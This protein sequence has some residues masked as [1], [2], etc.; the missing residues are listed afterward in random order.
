M[1]NTW[2][3]VSTVDE[4]IDTLAN[5]SVCYPCVLDLIRFK[6]AHATIVGMRVV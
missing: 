2:L 5:L 1:R 6:E 3:V 4:P